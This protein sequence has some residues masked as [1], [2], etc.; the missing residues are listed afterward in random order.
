[1]TSLTSSAYGSRVARHGSGRRTRAY[2]SSSAALRTQLRLG[3]EVHRR[4]VAVRE[5][6]DVDPR[7]ERPVRQREERVELER[8]DAAR[9]AVA[10]PGRLVRA[11]L[12]RVVG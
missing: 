1:M 2:Q 12:H 5:G 11:P 7:D 6:E 3:D 9:V 8:R 10:V 4:G